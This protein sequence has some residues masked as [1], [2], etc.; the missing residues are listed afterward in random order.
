MI[1]VIAASVVFVVV[2]VLLRWRA[3]ESEYRY[4]RKMEDRWRK[5]K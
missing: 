5:R 2:Y 3:D 1:A 4:H